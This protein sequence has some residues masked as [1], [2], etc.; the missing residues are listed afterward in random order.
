MAKQ[1]RL[2]ATPVAEGVRLELDR[3]T[4][5]AVRN[6]EK[7]ISVRVRRE[8]RAFLI[9]CMHIPFL[10]GAARLIRDVI[11]F[12]DG[13]I[14]SAELRP[15]R[16]VKGTEHERRIAG[17][18]H[19]RP[20]TIV[21]LTSAVLILLTGF[22]CLYAFPEG[23]AALLRMLPLPRLW[24]NLIAAVVRVIGLLFGVGVVGRLRVFKRLLMY[25]GAANKV[26]NCY[27]C[28]EEVSA[29]SVADYPILT[30]RSESAFL[31]CALSIALLLFPLI[32]PV[33]VVV[34]A[35][36]RVAVLLGVAAVLNEQFCALEEAQMTLPVRI[37]R[38]P[39]DFLQHMTT[40]EPHPQMLEVAVCA[41]NAAMQK[42][43]GEAET[44]VTSDDHL[45]MDE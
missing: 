38:T 11:R 37:A 36:L 23:A 18:L 1:R 29:Q 2:S 34:A 35:L 43:G 39:I 15:Q 17:F 4:V 42:A 8:P 32:P 14:E 10:R 41:F 7:D 45:G 28:G 30:R 24:L 9:A 31:L 44:E 12:F 21:T 40:L 26:I 27:E 16:P 22:I 19:I 6:E 33:N 25:Q 5:F 20:Q 13:L 3:Y